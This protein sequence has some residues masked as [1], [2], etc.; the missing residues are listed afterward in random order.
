MFYLCSLF[1]VLG[2]IEYLLAMREKIGILDGKHS[3]CRS[4]VDA[5][6]GG[7]ECFVWMRRPRVPCPSPL[8]VYDSALRAGGR[9]VRLAPRC[10]WIAA[11]FLDRS[12]FSGLPAPGGYGPSFC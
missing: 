9:I 8:V 5:A 3:S 7:A 12:G 1:F 6:A 11:S 4:V 2:Q 10:A